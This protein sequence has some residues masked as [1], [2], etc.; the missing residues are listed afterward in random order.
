MQVRFG[1]EWIALAGC[2][3][4]AHKNAALLPC[5]T[6]RSVL[7]ADGDALCSDLS[8][9]DGER[10]IERKRL[11]DLWV[12]LSLPCSVWGVFGRKAKGGNTDPATPSRV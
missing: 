2:H 3:Q 8:S 9:R 4:S 6:R 11:I 7:V 12:D 10:F 1:G 5:R